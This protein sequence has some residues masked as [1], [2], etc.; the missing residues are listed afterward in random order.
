MDRVVNQIKF[1]SQTEQESFTKIK[2]WLF[3]CIDFIFLLQ[4]LVFFLFCFF[5]WNILEFGL[6]QTAHPNPDQLVMNKPD[7]M[8]RFEY[9]RR[10]AP[11]GDVQF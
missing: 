2:E 7:Q 1:I 6:G 4:I 11:R 8:N 5:T 10:A 3:F 9:N